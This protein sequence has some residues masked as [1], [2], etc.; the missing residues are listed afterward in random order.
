M[1]KNFVIS[2]S[3][4]TVRREH[5]TREFDKH[6]VDFEFFNA[7]TPK[8][9]DIQLNRLQ[10]SR[11]KFDE[12][13]D[14]EMA[15]LLSHMCLWEK[16]VSENIEY[17]G[18]FEDDIYLG[19][20]FYHIVNDLSWAQGLAII[21][22]EKFHSKAEVSVFGQSISNTNRSL[23]QLLGKNLGTAGYILSQQG[24]RYMLK[25]LKS[26]NVI[27]AIDAV[28][29][30]QIK[31]PKNIPIYQVLPAVVIQDSIL[32]RQNI[33][34]TSSLEASR[35]PERKQSIALKDKFKR[36]L[37]RARRSLRMRKIKFE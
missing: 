13:S 34:L 15:C 32:N 2:L 17:I 35:R 23:H 22:L 28:M 36:E 37:D 33:N 3:S 1:I 31:F 5:I 26:L 18:I 16:A 9:L 7:I 10:I 30:N 24:A 27:D 21:K 11:D 4:H 29:F 12:L 25:Y 20:D 19:N 8:D 6:N 14:V